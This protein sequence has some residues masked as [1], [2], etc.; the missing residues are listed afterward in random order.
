MGMFAEKW[1]VVFVVI[2][3]M[4]WSVLLLVFMGIA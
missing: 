3:T 2:T 4:V 1:P